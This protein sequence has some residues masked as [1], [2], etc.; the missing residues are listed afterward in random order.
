M[1]GCLASAAIE[2]RPA[3]AKLSLVRLALARGSIW[4]RPAAL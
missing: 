3:T 4:N 2:V 1:D